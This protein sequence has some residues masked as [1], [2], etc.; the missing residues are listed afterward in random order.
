VSGKEGQREM[1][2][3][4]RQTWLIRVLSVSGHVLEVRT[5][6]NRA[7]RFGES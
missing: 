2:E 3:I 6:K 7:L 5:R 4:G 1:E